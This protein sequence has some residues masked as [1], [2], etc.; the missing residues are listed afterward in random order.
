MKIEHAFAF[1]IFQLSEK[2]NDLIYMHSTAQQLPNPIVPKW[3][4]SCIAHY[5][6]NSTK[7]TCIEKSK[8]HISFEAFI[9]TM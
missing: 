9:I 7:T 8:G 4:K 2:T 6:S 3:H 5:F 1:F